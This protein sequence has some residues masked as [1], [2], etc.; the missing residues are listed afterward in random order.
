MIMDHIIMVILKMVLKKVKDYIIIVMEIVIL[1]NGFKIKK[2]DKVYI[3]K[4]LIT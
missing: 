3:L 4:N 1:V 2:T